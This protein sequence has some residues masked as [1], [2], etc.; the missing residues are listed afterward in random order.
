MKPQ[1]GSAVRFIMLNVQWTG[2]V[3]HVLKDQTVGDI[4]SVAVTGYSET[5]KVMATLCVL[6]DP[7][8]YCCAAPVKSPDGQS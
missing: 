3:V 7:G 5:I 4:L 2:T 1:I 8:V 6:T